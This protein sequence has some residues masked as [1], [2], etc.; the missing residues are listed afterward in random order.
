MYTWMIIRRITAW[1]SNYFKPRFTVQN[2]GGVALKNYQAK[3]WFRVPEG[4]TL[5]VPVA[6]WYTPVSTP[7]LEKIDGSVWA[8]NLYFD[9]YILYPGESVAEGNVGLRLE[10]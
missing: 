3:L 6:D 2:T 8:L 9:K 4:K 7:S 5:F 10:D 1:E